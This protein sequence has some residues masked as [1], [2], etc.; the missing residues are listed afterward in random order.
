MT[1]LAAHGMR[2]VVALRDGRVLISSDGG[3]QWHRLPPLP[4]SPTVTA[5]AVSAQM[6]LVGTA[7]RGI[8]WTDGGGRWC[9]A[10]AES[11]LDRTVLTFARLSETVLAG[12]LRGGVF[13]STDLGRS[14]TA[15]NAGLPLHGDRLEVPQIA[16]TMSGWVALHAFG[17]SYSPDDGRRWTPLVAGL[18]MH[19]EPAVLASLD[20][21]LYAE[22]GA[23]LYRLDPDYRWSAAGTPEPILLVGEADGSLLAVLRDGRTLSRSD[24]DGHTWN[25]FQAGLP[26]AAFVTMIAATHRAVL[27]TLDGDG[28]W[29]HRL[30]A[31]AD[32]IQPL[33]PSLPHAALLAND[34]NPFA[35]ATAI[36][37]QL[38]ADAE[39]TLTVHDVFDIEVGRLA[40]ET[41]PAGL[42]RVV[43][44]AG[45]LP[46][47]L[48]QCRLLVAGRTHE[49]TMLLHR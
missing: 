35:N 34:P 9:P 41:L 14:W 47:G 17:A 13:R 6:V 30:P 38:S 5:A 37:F 32:T 4:G 2:A 3:S 44:E 31:I 21:D 11:L 40:E 45:T 48:Y 22:V 12:T 25:D 19:R 20:R 46:A 36:S 23:R 39:V 33:A 16:A 27:A 28:L 26:S 49:R 24:D 1:A 43:F 10:Y 15:A 18:P 42:H 7:G 8:F 29:S